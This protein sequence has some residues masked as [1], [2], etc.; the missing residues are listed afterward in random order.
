MTWNEIVQK[1]QQKDYYAKEL[2]PFLREE[3]ESNICFPPKENIFNALNATPFDSVKVVILGQD[4]YHEPGQAMGLSFSVPQGVKIPPSLV[5][6]FK[7]IENEFG[8]ESYTENLKEYGDLTSWATQGVLLLNT[9]LT[10]RKGEAR[11]HAG[12]GWEIFTDALIQELDSKRNGIVFML[13]GKDAKAKKK[14]LK[15]PNNAVMETS[16]PSPFSASRGFNGCNHF[17][18]CNSFLLNAGITP[19]NW[20]SNLQEFQAHM[21]SIMPQVQEEIEIPYPEPGYDIPEYYL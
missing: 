15:N 8:Y 16:H 17:K 7:E 19:I 3:Y 4:P 11:S 18:N 2:A 1:E 14:L 6:I 13:W 10:V 12:K 9:T 20:S 5:N 21:T